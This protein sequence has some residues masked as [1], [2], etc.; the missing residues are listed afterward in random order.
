MKQLPI[1]TVMFWDNPATIP[2]GW[3]IL[4]SSVGKYVLGANDDSDLLSTGGSESHLHSQPNTATRA[5]HNHGGS[6][7]TGT[8][9]GASTLPVML[10]SY[11]QTAVASHTHSAGSVQI[12]SDGGHGHSIG[13]TGSANNDPYHVEALIIEKIS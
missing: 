2:P 9:S 3:Q 8:T 12:Y 10:Y 5:A 11:A 1:G 4:T 7:S 13:N 6:M